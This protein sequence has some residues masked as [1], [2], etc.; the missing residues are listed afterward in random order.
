MLKVICDFNPD[1][2][3]VFGTEEVFSLIQNHTNIPVVIQI[4]GLMNPCFNNYFSP[5]L[6][7]KISFKF[8]IF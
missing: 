2:I 3:H 1:I 4:Q 7:K 6:V 8:K 5:E